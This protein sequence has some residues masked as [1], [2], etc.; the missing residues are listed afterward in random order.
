MST[1]GH[2]CRP[3]QLPFPP[4]L[5]RWSAPIPKRCARRAL[6]PPQVWVPPT[7]IV[8]TLPARCTGPA[9]LQSDIAR[10]IWK[11]PHPQLLLADLPQAGEAVWLDRE[12]EDDQGAD[13]HQLNVLH[14]GGADGH[15]ER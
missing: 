15:A 4:S 2:R 12:E 6:R 7:N 10:S 11:W 14:G 5:A 9:C 1:A 3:P 13:H 8:S